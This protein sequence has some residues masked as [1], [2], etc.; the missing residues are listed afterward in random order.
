MP[1]GA[2]GVHYGRVVTR[3]ITRSLACSSCGNVRIAPDTLQTSIPVTIRS[4]H[5]KHEAR[6]QFSIS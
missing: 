1:F 2:G 4:A 6:G 5:I 3:R